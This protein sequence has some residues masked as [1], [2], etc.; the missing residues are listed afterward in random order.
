MGESVGDWLCQHPADQSLAV[1]GDLRTVRTR[2]AK[3]IDPELREL[4]A[5]YRLILLPAPLRASPG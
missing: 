4:F 3:K 1:L 2:T 5:I